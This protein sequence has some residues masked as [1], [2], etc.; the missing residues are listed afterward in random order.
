MFAGLGVITIECVG[1][2]EGWS[3]VG[4]K[5]CVGLW[6]S[7]CM[8]GNLIK[9]NIVLEKKLGMILNPSMCPRI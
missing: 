8:N 7:Y 6:F 4:R 9:G 5:G 3:F 1:Y 2:V